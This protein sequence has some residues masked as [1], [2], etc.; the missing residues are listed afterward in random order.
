[1][2]I[3]SFGCCQWRCTNN[4]TDLSCKVCAVLHRHTAVRV[5]GSSLS[6][7][8]VNLL[9]KVYS[10]GLQYYIVCLLV[11]G[12][13]AAYRLRHRCAAQMSSW[14][15]TA[16]SHRHCSTQQEQHRT[17]SGQHGSAFQCANYQQDSNQVRTATLVVY[18]VRTTV[19]HKRSTCSISSAVRVIVQSVEVWAST[20]MYVRTCMLDMHTSASS[21]SLCC[22]YPVTHV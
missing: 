5:C 1:V 19:V 14:C 15:T 4:T 9:Y 18:S 22:L 17:S 8:T 7:Q 6:L 10:S 16:L 20:F 12:S 2:S 11:N 21:Q 3:L 13:F